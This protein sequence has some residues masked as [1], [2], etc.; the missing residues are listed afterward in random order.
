MERI[1]PF[2]PLKYFTV[3]VLF[4]WVHLSVNAQAD[5]KLQKA[6]NGLKVYTK[7]R[8]GSAVKSI[9]VEIEFDV[10]LQKILDVIMDVNAFPLWIYQCKEATLVKRINQDQLIYHHVTQ[11]PWPVADR[12]QYSKFMVTHHANYVTVHSEILS[13]FPLYKDCVRL[14]ESHAN[15]T[16]TPVDK[17][18]TK[19]VYT[20]SFDPAGNI[21][22]WLIN[23]F[24]TEGPYR[25][26]TN[27]KK[28]LGSN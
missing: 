8:E 20:L 4:F 22:A 26:F 6:G 2:T 3:F 16:L 5:W 18:H 9:K 17:Q 11:A 12:D 14:T 23:L 13:G 1:K 21:P 28:R 25:S 7:S 15:W 10:P 19:G 24:I 27:M